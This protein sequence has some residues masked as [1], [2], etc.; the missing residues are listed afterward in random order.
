[1][2]KILTFAL[3]AVALIV[4]SPA[5]AVT[6]LV[7]NPGFLDLDTDTNYG[8]AWGAYGAASFNAFW[9]PAN[10]HAS[11]YG[12][13]A[14]NEGGF[15]QQSIAGSAGVTYQFDVINTRIEPNWDADLYYGLEYYAADDATKLGETLVLADTA[16]RLANGTIDG[17]VFS[18]QGTA[19]AGTE[20]VRP[21]VSFNNVNFS[22]VGGSTTQANTF[23][24]N[25]HLAEAPGAGDEY[26]KNPGFE[27]EDG[28][29]DQGDFWG[30]YGNAGFNDFWGGNGHASLFADTAGNSGGIYQQAI[31]ATAGTTYEF[32]LLD[33]RI[34]E[35]FD[36]D[37]QF[38]LEYYGADDYAKL[39]ETLVTIDTNT[40]MVDGN[41]FTMTG[42]AV[43]DTVYIRPVVL[44]DNVVSTAADSESVFIFDASL[45]EFTDLPGDFNSDGTVDAADYTVWRDGLGTTYTEA[46]Y[47]IWKTHFGESAGSG[48]L[49]TAAVPEPI[50]ALLLLVGLAGLAGPCRRRCQLAVTDR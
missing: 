14:F 29:G 43:T 27:D 35:N 3:L 31:L 5:L 25:S 16:T 32:S 18:M 34:E 42:T 46:D 10:P 26:L 20:Y 24:F 9:G 44:F 36:A 37:L 2:N 39:G 4:C 15:F 45:T 12:D 19:V 6:N 8:D 33:V 23:V 11:L 13:D 47:G 28:Q 50:A 1:M 30:S 7:T 21:V 38:G 22:Y 41:S 40:G 48:A 49:Q 17:N